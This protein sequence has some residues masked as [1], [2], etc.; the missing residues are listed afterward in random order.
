MH[1][2]CITTRRQSKGL[3]GTRGTRIPLLRPQTSTFSSP[4]QGG[5]PRFETQHGLEWARDA[6]TD[7]Q[8]G[9]RGGI[10]R[11]RYLFFRRA[12]PRAR[13]ASYGRRR[14]GR[15]RHWTAP[16]ARRD[17]HDAHAGRPQPARDL[18]ISHAAYGRRSP[19]RSGE[20]SR[21]PTHHV[22][23]GGHRRCARP[24]PLARSRVVGELAQY[25]D[26]YRLCYIRGPE[27][28]LIGLAEQIG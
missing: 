11:C 5:G 4:L 13:R 23:R 18:A 8:R 24:A 6:S 9:H 1:S 2:V 14:L 19:E 15:A 16:H 27:G 17:R 20:R 7:G 22:R 3:N 28:I 10:T 25:E 12:R 26:E 21:L